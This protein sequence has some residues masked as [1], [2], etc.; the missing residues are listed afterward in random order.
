MNMAKGAR[1]MSFICLPLDAT[2]ITMCMRDA[3]VLTY[4]LQMGNLHA[5]PLQQRDNTAVVD[6]NQRDDADGVEQR[7]RGGGDDKAAAKHVPVHVGALHHKEAAHLHAVASPVS[8]GVTSP[9]IHRDCKTNSWTSPKQRASSS[10]GSWAWSKPLS[11]TRTVLESE[12]N[13]CARPQLHARLSLLGTV[14]APD[15]IQQADGEAGK[16]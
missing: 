6:G 16:P 13:S 10:A 5:E 14:T 3:W 4:A 1:C 8:S 9:Q 15:V 12:I 7:Q 11:C 2:A